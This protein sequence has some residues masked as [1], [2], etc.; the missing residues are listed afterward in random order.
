MRLIDA[1]WWRNKCKQCVYYHFENN[2]CQS[3]KV[4]TGGDGY[5][6]LLDRMLCK[7]RKEDHETD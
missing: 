3:K 1:D 2:T 6:T 7:P 5:V 4:T